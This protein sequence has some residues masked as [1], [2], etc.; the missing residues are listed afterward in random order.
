MDPF[1][2]C[3]EQWLRG[4][5]PDHHTFFDVGCRS[6]DGLNRKVRGGWMPVG[7]YR[8]AEADLRLLLLFVFVLHFQRELGRVFTIEVDDV[9]RPVPIANRLEIVCGDFAGDRELL[10]NS[11]VMSFPMEPF[12][13]AHKDHHH[14]R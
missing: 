1:L 7:W 13:S 9:E 6:A 14:V 10:A 11:G 2:I 12:Y 3:A 4:V 8:A 5:V